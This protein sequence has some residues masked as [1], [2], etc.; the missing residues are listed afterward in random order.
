M[1]K[2]GIEKIT[3]HEN[4]GIYLK[5]INMDTGRAREMSVKNSNLLYEPANKTVIMKKIDKNI[6]FDLVLNNLN[7]IICFM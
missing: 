1:K 6:N 3:F 7:D 2:S 5:R 4:K